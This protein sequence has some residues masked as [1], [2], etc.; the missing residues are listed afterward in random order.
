MKQILQQRA[1]E[2]LY[3]Y[4]H[5]PLSDIH[6]HAQACAEAAEA[7]AEQGKFWEMHETLFARLGL[8]D[9]RH[10]EQYA[11][12]LRLDM[13]RYRQAM[14]SHAHAD[15]VRDDRESGERSGVESTPTFYINGYR[16]DGANE[17]EPLLQALRNPI[18]A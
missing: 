11:E 4:R 15:K 16:Y 10:L 2:I 14:R 1:G 8:Q 3:A 6:P 7:A 17:L 9:E 13:D 12:F 5:F 18:G